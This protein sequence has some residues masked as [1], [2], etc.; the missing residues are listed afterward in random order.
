[1]L[2]SLLPAEYKLSI[3]IID[4]KLHIIGPLRYETRPRTQYHVLTLIWQA[5]DSTI[6]YHHGVISG[7]YSYETFSSH[8]VL[9]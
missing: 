6:I 4:L 1:M 2:F 9:P 3:N 8:A 5:T 7:H